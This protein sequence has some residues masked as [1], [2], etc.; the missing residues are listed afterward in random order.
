[1]DVEPG[2]VR[3]RRAEGELFA[4][5]K[6]QNGGKAANVDLAIADNQVHRDFHLT[7]AVT[8]HRIE[9]NTETKTAERPTSQAASANAWLSETRMAARVAAFRGPE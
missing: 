1:V 2:L 6:A 8:T 3:R 4:S 5:T 7:K 9:T